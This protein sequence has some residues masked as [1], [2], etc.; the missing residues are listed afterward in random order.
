[1]KENGVCAV[2]TQKYKRTTD[3]DHS[4]N[5]A[6]NLLDQDFSATVS[7]RKWA[8]DITHV[9]TREGWVYLAFIIDLFSR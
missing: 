4:F 6:P 2:R 9:L 5:I 8:G 7:N 3:S 1:M